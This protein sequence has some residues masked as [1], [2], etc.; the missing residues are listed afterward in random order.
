MSLV[1]HLPTGIKADCWCSAVGY[2]SACVL[3]CCVCCSQFRPCNKG[4][5]VAWVFGGRQVLLLPKSAGHGGTQFSVLVR[6][7]RSIPC[8]LLLVCVQHVCEAGISH[9]YFL[10]R[11]VHLRVDGDLTSAATLHQG[12]AWDSYKSRLYFQA[13]AR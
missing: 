6:S 7:F 3:P 12:V 13:C 10:V 4:C 9:S 5:C 2:E 11:V 1:Y 8:V